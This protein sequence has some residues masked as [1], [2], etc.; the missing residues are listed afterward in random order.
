MNTKTIIGI[1]VCFLLLATITA[2]CEAVQYKSR[3]LKKNKEAKGTKYVTSAAELQLNL[4]DLASVFTGVIEQT[5]DQVIKVSTINSV[6]QHALLWKINGIPTAYRALF[7]HDPAMA[8]LDTWAF[9][10]QMVNYF[11]HGEGKMDFGQWNQIALNSSLSLKK[12]L[13]QLIDTGLPDG[14]V[15]TLEGNYKSWVLEHPI[16]RDFIYRDTVVPELGSFIGDQELGTLQTVGSMAIGME[17]MADQIAV[18]MNLL[19]KQARWQ[20]ELILLETFKDQDPKA[21]LST[22]VE[23]ADSLNQISPVVAQ[24]PELIAQERKAFFET[25]QTERETILQSINEQRIATLSEIDSS[26]DRI[27]K[28]TMDQSKQLIDHLFIRAFQLL[29]ASLICG[30]VLAAIVIRLKGKGHSKQ[31]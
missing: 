18:Y 7:H 22:I 13:E 5:A 2:E 3:L 20:T 23:L 24:F 6:K 28:T 19:P 11:E 8:I 15:D 25:L 1:I 26:S 30:V 29:A 14:N 21:A 10:M 17:E 12:K 27:L 31:N 9:S 4:D 16:A